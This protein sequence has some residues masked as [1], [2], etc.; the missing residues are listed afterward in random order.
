MKF[1]IEGIEAVRREIE[2]LSDDKLKRKEILKILRRQTKPIL[3]A[4]QANTPTADQVV[5]FRGVK[6]HP[7]NLRKS[8]AIKTSPSKSY[9]NV[10]VGPRKGRN[11]RKSPKNDGFYAF[12]IQ[13]GTIHQKP[14]D[15]IGK[16]AEPL[17]AS[18]HTTASK[19]TERYIQKKIKTLNL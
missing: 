15:F 4:I 19:E 18:V 17:L 13:Y 2:S 16:A 14:N 6:Y 3:S 12:W 10:L 1:K 11:G 9:P 5:S 7:G 8:M